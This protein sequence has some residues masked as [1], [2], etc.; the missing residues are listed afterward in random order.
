VVVEGVAEGLAREITTQIEVPTIGIGASA[1]CDGQ[2]LVT[3]DMLGLF[4]WTPKFVRR[5]ADLRGD[6]T[7]A[8]G[9]FA[10][11]VRSGR[12]PSESE[13]YYFADGT[14][15]PGLYQAASA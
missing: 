14:P 5:Y 2:I 3:D 15:V 10:D 9:R 4:D 6:A 12:Y 8:V 1:G 7:A 13:T 11:D